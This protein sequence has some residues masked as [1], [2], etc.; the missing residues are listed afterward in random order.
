MTESLFVGVATPNT[1]VAVMNI[2]LSTTSQ[3]AGSRVDPVGCWS[4]CSDHA[5]LHAVAE[6]AGGVRIVQEVQETLTPQIFTAAAARHH[7]LFVVSKPAT[8]SL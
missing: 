2:I 6:T 5:A 4:C 8:L 3:V 7:S 1:D